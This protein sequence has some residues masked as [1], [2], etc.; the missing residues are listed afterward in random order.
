M[1]YRSGVLVKGGFI[2][3]SGT[4]PVGKTFRTLFRSDGH[5]AVRYE[6]FKEK[7]YAAREKPA[8]KTKADTPV[9]VDTGFIMAA[10][11]AHP[12]HQWK[13]VQL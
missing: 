4:A 7:E 10:L 1:H 9:V 13:G 6:D 8:G 3:K 12:L 11:N 2:V 5:S